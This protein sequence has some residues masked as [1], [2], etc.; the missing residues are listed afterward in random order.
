MNHCNCS[1]YEYAFLDNLFIYLTCFN[2]RIMN[3]ELLYIP[4]MNLQLFHSYNGSMQQICFLTNMEL[5]MFK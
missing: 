2:R 3:H 1:Y 5:N 4:T